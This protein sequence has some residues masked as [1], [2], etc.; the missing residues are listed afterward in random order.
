MLSKTMDYFYPPHCCLCGMAT[1]GAGLCR[2]CAADLPLNSQC[3]KICALPMETGSEDYICSDCLQSPPPFHKIFSP[4]IYAQPLEWMIQQLKFNHQLYFARL[5]AEQMWQH[6]NVLKTADCIIPVPLHPRRLKQRGFN[7]SMEIA[8][9]LGGLLSIPVDNGCCQRLVNTP[10]QTGKTASSRRRNIRG[11]FRYNG[12]HKKYRHVI[13]L[14]DV[15]TTGSTVEA[16][17]EILV[18]QGVE[19]IDVWSV[20]RAG[21]GIASE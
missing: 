7:Q 19:R 2:A 6:K 20:A 21:K 9:E 13:V 4:F 5:L 17:A 15:I 14:D 3:C 1:T 8:R 16:L 18:Q 11:A 12:S 10:A